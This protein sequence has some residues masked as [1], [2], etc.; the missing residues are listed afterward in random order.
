MNGKG[1][2]SKETR[3]AENDKWHEPRRWSPNK[4]NH[5]LEGLNRLHST[6]HVLLGIEHQ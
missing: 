3:E 5:Q 4:G 6:S 1:L 2:Q